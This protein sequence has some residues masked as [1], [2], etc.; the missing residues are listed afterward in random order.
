MM[1]FGME[2]SR[3]RAAKGGGLLS[4]VGVMRVG[5]LALRWWR[6]RRARVTGKEV[7]GRERDPNPIHGWQ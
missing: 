2:R 1:L 4:G 3:G 6:N 5:R 7:R